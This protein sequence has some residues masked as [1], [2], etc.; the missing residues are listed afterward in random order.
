MISL[1]FYQANAQ[2]DYKKITPKE[3]SS[4]VTISDLVKDLPADCRLISF[5][6]SF[7]TPNGLRSFALEKDT[8]SSIFK[9]YMPNPKKGQKIFVTLSGNSCSKS[10]PKEFKYIIDEK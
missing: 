6:L 10:K 8:I 4:I 5:E 9:E 1:F 2:K 3:L 7:T